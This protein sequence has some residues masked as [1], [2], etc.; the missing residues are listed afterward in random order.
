MTAPSPAASERSALP[1]GLLALDKPA[2]ITSHGCVGAAR[3]A[4]GTRK[5]GHAGTL[6]PMATGVLILGVGR[7]TRLLGHLALKD[8][9]YGATMRL[10]STTITDDREG[11]VLTV[12]DPAA[13][14]RVT[15]E[16]I[17]AAISPLTGDIEQVPTAISAIKVDG[18]RAHALVRAGEE[19][20]LKSRRVTVERFEILEIRRGDGWI[21][22]DVEVTCS[23]GTYVRALARDLGADLGVGGHLTALRR[24][25]VGPWSVGDCVSWEQLTESEDPR[26]L[27]LGLQDAARR[28]FP[29]I[30]LDA[31][32]ALWVR[33]GRPLRELLPA[34]VTEVAALLG[35]DDRLL[36]L[37]G[38]S[39]RGGTYLAVFVP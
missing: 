9:D 32:G 26:G 27:L 18:K 19:V 24:T 7:G 34:P 1:V 39:E 23:T 35:P 2:G 6:D 12:A 28:S 11:D 14:G 30:E 29:V 31:A 3:R 8:K 5:V 13:L 38:P 21:D 20:D 15:D 17:R 37:V 36:A 16:A 4:L 25:R 33:N 10:G 22:V